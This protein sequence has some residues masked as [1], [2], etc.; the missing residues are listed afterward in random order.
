M[1]QTI[2]NGGTSGHKRLMAKTFLKGLDLL[3]TL[4][5]AGRPLS[6]SEISTLLE[7]P[8]PSVHF[9]LSALTARGYA[10][11]DPV[12]KRYFLTLKLWEIGTKVLGRLDLRR[13]ASAHLAS[14][15]DA[16]SETV[17]LAILDHDDVLYLEKIDSPMP[18]RAY[19]PVGQRAPAYCT[20][21]GKALIA[22][23]S[24][25][26]IS[27]ATRNMKAHSP[28]TITSAHALRKEL[29]RV[30]KMGYAIT[31]GEWQ[32]S[33]RGVAVPIWDSTGKVVA[34]VGVYGPA[35][36]LP[37]KTLRKLAL[38]VKKTGAAISSALGYRNL[39]P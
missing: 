38:K 25:E 11:Q 5:N 7:A 17:N 39:T 23:E 14:L 33:V 4:A 34:A 10:E 6:L 1:A 9:L 31:R 26:I 24:E 3:E 21:T 22:Y 36:R 27:R 35:S 16:T 13:L 32:E 37:P 29:E 18:V 30:K 12:T 8:K 15:A 2:S 20:A 28:T 19:T